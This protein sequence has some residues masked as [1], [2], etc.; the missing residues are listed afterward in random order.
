MGLAAYLDESG[1][2]DTAILAVAGYVATGEEWRRFSRDWLGALR[3]NSV[4]LLHMVDLEAGNPPFDGWT[5]K[6]RHDLFKR[7][8]G[9]LNARVVFQTWAAVDVKECERVIAECDK[10]LI[11]SPYVLCAVLCMLFISN[12]ARAHWKKEQ[13]VLFFEEGRPFSGDMFRLWHQAVCKPWLRERYK[14]AAIQKESK[15]ELVPFQAADC[16]AYEVRKKYSR[17]TAPIRPYL[18]WLDLGGRKSK[19]RFFGPAEIEDFIEMA[20]DAFDRLANPSYLRKR[21]ARLSK[22]RPPSGVGIIS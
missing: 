1:D 16:L 19:G 18:K 4:D 7:L 14:L 11:A 12:W 22:R 13:V 17:P 8:S 10:D 3:A 5:R 21:D 15:K 2:R 20:N 6:R 9:I